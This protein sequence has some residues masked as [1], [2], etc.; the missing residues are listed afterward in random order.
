MLAV[1]AL[2]SLLGVE[3]EHVALLIGSTRVAA[4]GKRCVLR[5][6]TERERWGGGRRGGWEREGED[7]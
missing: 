1:R 4:G 5:G 2:H 7:E 6:R 3:L